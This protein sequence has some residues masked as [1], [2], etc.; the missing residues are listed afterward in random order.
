MNQLN[1]SPLVLTAPP[2]AARV[3]RAA[4]GFFVAGLVMTVAALGY[5]LLDQT[6]LGGLNAQLH[7]V[8]DSYGKH[9]R[10]GALYGYLYALGGL[11]VVGWLCCL[12]RIRRSPRAARIWS[13][14]V[15]VLSAPAIA[16]LLLQEYGQFVFPVSFA[17]IYSGIWVLGLVGTV[18]LFRR[19]K[20]G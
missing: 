5:T 12:N 10:P 16:P 2:P 7:A 6:V 13:S 14:S 1:G 19:T 8:Y 20:S 3:S 15:L 11:G 9:V 17:A 18:L 4:V